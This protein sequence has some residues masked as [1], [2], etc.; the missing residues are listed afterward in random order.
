[1]ERC[2]TCNHWEPI[3][4]QTPPLR[5]VCECDKIRDHH[6]PPEADTLVYS[7]DE[8]GEF[9]AGAEFGCVHHKAK[10]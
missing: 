10:A 9:W 2:K 6:Y 5:G 3:G 4:G 8:G 7:Y 1:M